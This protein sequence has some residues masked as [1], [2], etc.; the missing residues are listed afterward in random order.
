MACPPGIPYCGGV[1]GTGVLNTPSK[2]DSHI[3][4]QRSVDDSDRLLWPLFPRRPLCKAPALLR[5]LTPTFSFRHFL[6]PSPQEKNA[7]PCESE[8]YLSP[9]LRCTQAGA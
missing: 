5:L 8:G 6:L 4:C 3:Y 1:T 2:Q 7:L 9:A